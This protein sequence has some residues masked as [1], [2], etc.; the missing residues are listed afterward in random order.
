MCLEVVLPGCVA[1]NEHSD[2]CVY[3]HIT[4][5]WWN[6]TQYKHCVRLVVTCESRLQE[7]SSPTGEV[8]KVLF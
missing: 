3:T 4:A 1:K 2:L 5:S 6:S 8:C 7:Q